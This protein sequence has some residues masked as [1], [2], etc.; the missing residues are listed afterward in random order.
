MSRSKYATPRP[1]KFLFYYRNS[2]Q[3]RV[4]DP[5]CIQ[6]PFVGFRIQIQSAR[7]SSPTFRQLSSL[8]FPRQVAVR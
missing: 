6:W 5:R 4:K 1:V 2:K 8:V 7:K 3:R